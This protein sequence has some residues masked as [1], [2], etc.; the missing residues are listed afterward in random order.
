[1]NLIMRDAL[2]C[3]SLEIVRV[4][5][6]VGRCPVCGGC[7]DVTVQGYDTYLDG[8]NSMVVEIHAE[9][10]SEDI[11]DDDDEHWEGLSMPYVDWLPI[12]ERITR[13]LNTNFVVEE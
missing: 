4:P 11:E 9:C 1:M 2:D 5:I 6:A 7:F 13:W 3:E 8:S 10:E 12:Q